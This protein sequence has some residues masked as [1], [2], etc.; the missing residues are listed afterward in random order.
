MV[1]HETQPLARDIL[2]LVVADM[3]GEAHEFELAHLFDARFFQGHG[4]ALQMAD[5]VDEI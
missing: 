2:H 1:L 5:G 3:F 4:F